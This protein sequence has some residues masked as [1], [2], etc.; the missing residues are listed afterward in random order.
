MYIKFCLEGW[1]IHSLPSRRCLECRIRCPPMGMNAQAMLMGHMYK[2]SKHPSLGTGI[3]GI[4]NCKR[5]FYVMQGFS[6]R[7]DRFWSHARL[8]AH[9]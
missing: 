3:K 2:A 6:T 1:P 7:A 8:T 9:Q 4:F 5:Y